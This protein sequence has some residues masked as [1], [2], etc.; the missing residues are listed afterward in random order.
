[1]PVELHE[2]LSEFSYGYGVTREAEEALASVG[3]RAVPFLPNLLH[4]AELGFDVGFDRP[5]V[6]LL[7][8]FKLGQAMRRFVPGPGPVL[9]RPFWRFRIDTAEADGQYELLLKAEQDGA[10]TYYVAPKFHDWQAYLEAYGDGLVISS[11]LLMTPGRIRAALDASGAP[12]G[13]HK[14]VY[15]HARA[16]L[17]SDPL[18]LTVVR[19]RDF[20]KRLR[21]RIEKEDVRLGQSMRRV[22]AG[23]TERA[24]VRRSRDSQAAVSSDRRAFSIAS[25]TGTGAAVRRERFADYR[26]RS[27]SLDEAITA[28]VGAETWAAGIQM[29]MVTLD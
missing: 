18:P 11:S 28:A 25:D 24:Q 4:E 1:M 17:C 13:P 15:D 6:P 8:Q 7:L 27:K 29:I 21:T 12:D 5:G 10:E 23:F 20:A 2:R 22:F 26:G 9:N 16:Y 3:L 14:L 19:S